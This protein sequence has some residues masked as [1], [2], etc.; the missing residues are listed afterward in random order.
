MGFLDKLLGRGKQI[1]DKGMGMAEGVVDH[2]GD[3]AEK[4]MTAAEGVVDRAGDMADKAMDKAEDR[5]GLGEEGGESADTSAP[6]PPA[7][8][9]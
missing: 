2:A 4:G 6:S 1:A 5:L 7:E 9:A 8:S 3:M